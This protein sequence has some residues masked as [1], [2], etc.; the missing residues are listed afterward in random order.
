M[1]FLE[2]RITFQNVNI[3]TLQHVKLLEEV[4]FQRASKIRLL[5][6]KLYFLQRNFTY[7]LL[8]DSFSR[9]GLSIFDSWKETL[10]LLVNSI[11]VG[12]SW[13]WSSF[14]FDLKNSAIRYFLSTFEPNLC[15]LSSVDS[16]MRFNS[17]LGTASSAVFVIPSERWY[18]RQTKSLPTCWI[19][20]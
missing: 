7:L 6:G 3:L 14:D 13:I 8:G 20:I 1:W 11:G 5:L 2:F 10:D 9:F 19:I 12:R 4:V 18:L 17:T 15:L 16:D